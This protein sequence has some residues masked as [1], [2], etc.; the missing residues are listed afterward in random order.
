MMGVHNLL[1]KTAPQMFDELIEA[2]RRFA[3]SGAFDDD[4]CLVGV[5]FAGKPALKS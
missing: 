4:V 5:E 3:V 1:T 2:I